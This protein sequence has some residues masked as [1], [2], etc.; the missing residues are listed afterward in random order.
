MVRVHLASISK[1]GR[2]CNFLEVRGHVLHGNDNLSIRAISLEDCKNYCAAQT[3][4]ECLSLEY[5]E[6]ENCYLSNNSNR[7]KPM[8]FTRNDNADYYENLCTRDVR[9]TKVSEAQAMPCPPNYFGCD[10]S[11]RTC[12]PDDWRC[13]DFPDCR[14]ESD[15]LQCPLADGDTYESKES[16]SGTFVCMST[17][18]KIPEDRYCDGEQDC[19][20]NSDEDSCVVEIPQPACDEDEFQCPGNPECMPR[21]W[22]CDGQ[23]DCQDGHD[24]SSCQ[25]EKEDLPCEF[26][27]GGNGRGRCIPNAF[28]CDGER[29]CNNGIDE[30]MCERSCNERIHF[31]CGSHGEPHCIP[32][33]FICDGVDDCSDGSDE[34]NCHTN[35]CTPAQFECAS[36]N[37]CEFLAWICDGEADCED[38]SDEIDCS[39]KNCSAQFQFMCASDERCIPKV[40]QCDGETDCRDGSDEEVMCCYSY[41][42]G[43]VQSNHPYYTQFQFTQ[44]THIMHALISPNDSIQNCMNNLRLRLSESEFCVNYCHQGKLE[45]RM[46]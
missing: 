28:V 9:P 44:S 16:D 1:Y 34:E 6:K 4:P 40:W 18:L 7:T 2:Q 43:D 42:V 11:D 15:E 10:F 39:G 23:N 31:T 8:D 32:K 27:C 17:G 30:S 36:K 3:E 38:G 12:I 22:L 26:Y 35:S 21:E 24:E 13:D 29:H 5:D 33:F 45:V 37:E 41:G 20:D 46:K 25:E 14:D 19:S